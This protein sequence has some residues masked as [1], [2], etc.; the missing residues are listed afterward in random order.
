MLHLLLGRS[1]FGKTHT[2]LARL[3]ELARTEEPGLL[4][5]LVPEQFSFE[6]E[7]ALLERLGPRL[8]VAVKVWSFTR[9]AD[10]VSRELGGRAGRR[11]DDATR[12]LLMS[13][14]LE[15]VSDRL[16]V[17]RRQA[18]DPEYVRE[19]LSTL[20]EF[21]QCAVGPRQ[22][23]QAAAAVEEEALRQKLQDL[24]LI[25]GAYDALTASAYVD[26]LDDLSVLA[27]RLSESRI[28]CGARVFVD[29]F[30]GF[31]GQEMRVLE[32]IL[33]RAREV[34]VTLCTDSPSDCTG[35][36]GLFAPVSETAE[37][38]RD[39]AEKN[40]VPVAKAEVLERNCRSENEAL[41]LVEAGCFR[42]GEKRM[43]EPTEAVTV[44]AC[45]DIY[46]ECAFAAREIH[47]LLR[48]EGGHFRDFAVVVRSTAE[49]EGVLD[50]ALEKAGIAYYM[51]RRE[52][53]L[54]DALPVLVLSALRAAES[55]D[56]EEILRL[57]KT[58]LTG[59]SPRSL[60]LLENYVYLW[61]IKGSGWREEWTGNPDGLSAPENA[62]TTRRLNH[63]NR[64]RR[65]AVEPL[66]RLRSALYPGRREERS[67][68]IGGRDFST[69]VYRYLTQVQ[70]ARLVRLQAARLEKQGERPL[71][72]RMGRV[73]NVLMD[74]LDRIAEALRDSRF[75]ASRFA[76]LLRLS[77]DTADL[78][79]IPQTLDAVQVGAADH[80]RFSSPKT[81][82][83]LG[84]NEGVFPR[85]PAG[86]GLISD[87]ERRR[88]IACGLPIT[89]TA[90][91]ETAEERFFAYMALSAPSQKLVVSYLTADAAGQRLMP[92]VL[93]ETVTV[94]LPCCRRCFPPEGHP[95]EVETEAEAFESAASLWRRESEEGASLRALFEEDSEK[96]EVFS[97]RLRVL[98]RAG[99]DSPAA[100]RSSE[101]AGRFFGKEMR[102]SPSRVE[103]YH[104]CR[105]AY[106]CRYGLRARA[107]RPADLDALEF[108]TL[109][110][111]VMEQT[112][113]VYVREDFTGVDRNRT[114]KDAYAA[115]DRY[116]DERMGGVE[117][118]SNRFRY[119]LTRLHRIC[120]ALL[121]QV[122]RELRQS[123]FRPAD[124]ELPIGHPDGETEEGVRPLTLTLPDGARISVQG[125][126]DRV[127]VCRENGRTYLRVVD[128]KTGS[129]QFDLSQVA[130][131][132]NLQ[133][134]IYL[135][136]IWE[137]GGER[138][139]PVTPAGVLY[140][141]ARLPLVSV[142]RDTQ[143]E[144]LEKAQ[145]RAM[146][147][148]GLLLDDPAV[149]EAMEP[150]AAGLF[151][152][153]KKNA[154]GEFDRYSSLATLGQ[155]GLIKR[156]IEKLL[157]Q[158]AETL[159][160]GDIAAVPASGEAD[161]C[162][163]C[164]YRAVCGREQEDPVHYIAARDRAELFR[165]W[166]KEEQQENSGQ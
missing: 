29:S 72:R 74:L 160:S 161:A 36:F 94:L 34:T 63:L 81:V 122:V 73:W 87:R 126:V 48:T 21:R 77:L 101:I 65:R 146:R 107:R 39:L 6:S 140:L 67:R 75:P 57:M 150:G 142:P 82:L 38:L 163:Y 99:D 133:M 27:D 136:A 138:Y 23:E 55:W 88:L 33:R 20:T 40:G 50:T 83:V 108:G 3:E 119:L 44:A 24:S 46:A 9:L 157:M 116:V 121:W 1:G 115:I 10:A 123:R 143:G 68:R 113:P 137:N 69:A 96:T 58:G 30:K 105:Y 149:I 35:G 31:T 2:V 22:L 14:A 100:F 90:D 165:E 45:A 125:K 120:A 85:T 166:E 52:D 158:M 129:K 110:H 153:A 127:D 43:E 103:A 76:E 131:G 12:T 106:F 151:I 155:F 86:G 111:Y 98:E 104:L 145:T 109:A 37:R 80:I 79:E 141:P 152:P 32:G 17:Y 18:G 134:L 124:Y 132:L 78:G 147:M 97:S 102:L 112:V 92:S 5:L 154:K 56:T 8:A 71:A 118:K 13:A 51:D 162:A 91:R 15:Q 61:R 144:E 28:F 135:M 26:P 11:M 60:S 89:N 49:Y 19:M 25:L 159:R 53:L 59:C 128:Y 139:G 7:R 93:A 117:N 95:A 41:R 84:A 62:S 16:T 4:V 164:D 47:R 148:N 66:E 54:S 70:A 42:P 156:R 114:E 130:E 64:L